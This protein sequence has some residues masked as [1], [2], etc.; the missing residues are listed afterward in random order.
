MCLVENQLNSTNDD[1]MSN[2]QHVMS[3]KSIQPSNRFTNGHLTPLNDYNKSTSN[4]H[5]SPSQIFN[6][7]LSLNSININNNKNLINNSSNSNSSTPSN[8]NTLAYQRRFNK[9]VTLGNT[10]N[11]ITQQQSQSSSLTATSISSPTN[12]VNN[13]N[14]NNNNNLTSHLNTLSINSTNSNNNNNNNIVVNGTSS[15]FASNSTLSVSP[16]KHNPTIPLFHSKKYAD[17][18]RAGSTFY[19]CFLL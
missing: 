7:N 8:G 1:N 13:N 11:N 10:N 16:L 17:D 15:I 19:V 12:V 18:Y 3:V 2:S 9:S 14:N 5:N 6:S 4:L